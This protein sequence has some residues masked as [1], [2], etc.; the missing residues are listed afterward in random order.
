VQAHVARNGT[1]WR[2]SSRSQ[3]KGARERRRAAERNAEALRTGGAVE[4]TV[5]R[6]KIKRI[7]FGA[8]ITL[9]S[10][11]LGGMTTMS[12][13]MTANAVFDRSPRVFVPVQITNMVEI[14]HEFLFREYKLQF[15]RAQDVQ[16]I[17]QLTTPQH[18]DEFTVPVGIAHV[19]SGRFGWRWIETVEPIPVAVKPR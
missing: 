15:R 8:L 5:P 1:G 13:C 16:D 10:V 11:L 3:S 17:E 2:R 19:R 7:G 9:G 6:G 12:F 18:L 4:L 14:T